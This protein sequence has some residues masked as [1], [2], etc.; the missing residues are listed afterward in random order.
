[1]KITDIV[2]QK[3]QVDEAPVGMLKRA[4]LGIASKLGSQTAKGALNTATMAN[5]LRKQFDYYLGQSGQK[6]NSDAIIAFL[7]ANGFPTAGAEAAIKQAAMAAGTMP[8]KDMRDTLGIGKNAGEPMATPN[9]SGRV[10]P[11]LDDPEQPA[12]QAADQQDDADVPKTNSDEKNWD[13][14]EEPAY[15]RKG[16]KNPAESIDELS[17]IAHLA[18]TTYRPVQEVVID[19]VDL[20]NSTVDSIIKAAV[21][22]ILKANMGQKLDAMISGQGAATTQ[23]I[24]KAGGN[25]ADNADGGDDSPQGFIAGLKRG[26]A[27]GKDDAK[28][29]TK[30]N[31]NYGKL[32]DMLPGVDPNQLKK[33]ITGYMS[34][35]PLTREH[36]GVMSSAFGEILKMDP[37]QKTQV[38]QILKAMSAR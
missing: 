32:T 23:A 1:M 27:G 5:G 24:N 12:D 35:T 26:L 31:L 8:A 38:L 20:K 21:Q 29:Q 33:A 13:D 7:G 30:G 25:A 19:E 17:R 15:K 2:S 37:A 6:P 14:Y 34:G 4:G 11:T 3:Q 10:E 22:D 28:T 36:M 16:I 18:G 9:P